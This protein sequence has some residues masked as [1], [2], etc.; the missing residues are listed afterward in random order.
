MPLWAWNGVQPAG[1]FWWIFP[2][3][4]L[5]VMVLM[6]FACL[7][8]MGGTSGFGCRGGRGGHSDGETEDLR[9]EVQELKGEIRKLHDRR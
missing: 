9:R 4:G 5:V 6:A 2:L 3:L 7:C 1:G 8:M